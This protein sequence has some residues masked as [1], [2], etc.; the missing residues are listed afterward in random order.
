MDSIN[1]IISRIRNSG[2]YGEQTVSILFN[3]IDILM[4]TL[5]SKT[6]KENWVYVCYVR[7]SPES[8]MEISDTAHNLHVT[9]SVTSMTNWYTL[10]AGELESNRLYPAASENGGYAPV[11]SHWLDRKNF[12]QRRFYHGG[13]TESGKYAAIHVAKIR[14]N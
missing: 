12:F 13:N 6:K 11:I 8:N 1:N 3:V 14:V 7:Y 10:N 4:E 2:D 9:G 5:E